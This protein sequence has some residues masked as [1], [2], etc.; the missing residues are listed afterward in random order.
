[1]DCVFSS[2][3]DRTTPVKRSPFKINS[4]PHSWSIWYSFSLLK[5][6]LTHLKPVSKII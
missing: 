4:V 5:R 6:I 1:M 2:L 3:Y